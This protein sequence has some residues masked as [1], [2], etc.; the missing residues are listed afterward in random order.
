MSAAYTV[1]VASFT[2]TPNGL[3]RTITES[4][5]E[6][7]SPEYAYRCAGVGRL[8]SSVPNRPRADIEAST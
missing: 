2:A 1:F 4:V 7:A 3:L 8:P 5:T 6:M